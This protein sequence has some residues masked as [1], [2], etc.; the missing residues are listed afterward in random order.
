MNI[1]ALLEE[2]YL[3][4]NQYNFIQDD[5]IQIP[6]Q[7]T[8]KQDIEI[9]GFFASILA[10][11]QRKTIINKCNELIE[12]MDHAPHQFIIGHEDSD[13]K[14]LLNFKHRTFNDIDLQYFIHFL[15]HHYT[16]SDSLETAFPV[17]QTDETIE[18]ALIHFRNYFISLPYFSQR[19]GKHIATPAK[20]AACKRIC[21]Y[22]RWMVRNDDKGVD[23]GI[24]KNIQP[25]QLITP[26]DVH[27][28]RVARKLQI[29]QREKTDWKAAVE[30]T[31]NL[32]Q[33]DPKD[34]VKYDFALFGMGVSN[35]I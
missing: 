29:L 31:Q 12:R 4:F 30:L 8:K 32:K 2:K 26:L 33:F 24:W 15:N 27:V 3:E 18:N 1:H 11:G 13:L 5:P 25:S 34:P 14:K 17:Q 9:T 20:N 6:H 19:K 23:F 35:E 28:D 7:F 16:Q 10:W 21:M 22:L